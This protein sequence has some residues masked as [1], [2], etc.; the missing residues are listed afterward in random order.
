MGAFQYGLG[1][2]AGLTAACPMEMGSE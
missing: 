1:G 2:V